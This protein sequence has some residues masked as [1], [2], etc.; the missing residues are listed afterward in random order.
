MN[1]VEPKV[2]LVGETRIVEDGLQDYLNHLGVSAWSTDAPSDAEKLCEVYGRLCYRSF[3]PGLNPNVTRVRKGNANYLG[4]VLEVGHGSVIEHAVLNFVF[5]DVSRVF[6]HELVRHRAGTAI[7][8]ESLRFVRLDRLSAFMPSHIRED[9]NGMEIYAKTLEQL[10]EVQRSLAKAYAIEDESKFDRKKK[11]TSA[12]RRVAPEGLATTIGWSCNF[13]ALRHVI[14]M[15]TAPDA[16]EELRVVFGK[17]YET[18]KDRY[19]SLMGD[20][21]VEMADG[22]PW[23]KT[24]N[25]KV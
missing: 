15:R 14:E 8:Q 1:F 9:D 3:E 4:H 6:T 19:P 21:E 10:E 16:E 25:K 23:V 7:S 24:T 22:L 2:F 18:V 13:R 11:L 17:V 20:Y 12:F 5:A